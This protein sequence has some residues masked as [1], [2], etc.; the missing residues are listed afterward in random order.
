MF[1]Y[2][3]FFFEIFKNIH[4]N[5]AFIMFMSLFYSYPSMSSPANG[6]KWG[7]PFAACCCNQSSVGKN[8][9]TR[10]YTQLVERDLNHGVF[11]VIA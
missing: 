1:S 8:L 10:K 9:H 3:N 11:L 6:V 2:Y 7:T 5:Q 4:I